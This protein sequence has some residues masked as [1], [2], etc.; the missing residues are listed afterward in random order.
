MV[1]SLACSFTNDHSETERAGGAEPMD[2]RLRAA[3]A[4]GA[5]SGNKCA[6]PVRF[7]RPKADTSQRVSIIVAGQE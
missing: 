2:C 7:Y 5:G 3:N 1:T 4:R 6:T